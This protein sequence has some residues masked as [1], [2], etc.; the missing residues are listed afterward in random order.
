MRHDFLK[1]IALRVARSVRGEGPARQHG[2]ETGD[3]PLADSLPDVHRRAIEM[4][5]EGRVAFKGD[6]E[7]FSRPLI[8]L[9]FT[10]RSGSN[11]LADYL[12]QTNCVAGLGEY[13]NRETVTK[14]SR[15]LNVTNLPDYI[16]YLVQKLSRDDQQFG[17]KAS[18]EQLRFL[19]QWRILRM[20][21]SVCVVH[22]HR[23][24]LLAQAV[25]HWIARQTG[26][27][28]SLHAKR[29]DKVTFDGARMV[30]I[31]KDIAL[32]DQAIRMHCTFEGLRYVSVSYE[33]VQ[34]D[35]VVAVNR[36]AA[37]AGF[38]TS[39]WEPV[40]PRISKQSDGRNTELLWQM[41]D[42]IVRQQPP[43]EM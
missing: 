39:G 30:A 23:D 22:I 10:N 13:L 26:Q 41:R 20:F 4:Q 11:L 2:V 31:A 42:H 35:P 6:S 43:R 37:A 29:S 27:W 40:Q 17:V 24:D 7:L 14:K 32:A 3:Q 34:A 9:A 28:T 8:V 38:D 16:G 19:S 5:F 21:P 25:S 1:A 15:E 36:I 18:A 33:E 12:R